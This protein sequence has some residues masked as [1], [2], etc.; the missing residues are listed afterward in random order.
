M[1]RDRS[2]FKVFESKKGGNVT[3]GDGSKSQIKGKRIISLPGLLDIANMLYVECL[4]VNLLSISQIFDQ[5]FM[6]L[7]S[8]GKCLVLDKSGKKLISGVRT[9]DNC[10]SLN[11]VVERKNRVFQEMARAMLHNKGVARNLWGETVN[12]A[13]HTVNRVYFR[14]DTKKTPYELWKGRKPNV[15]YFRIFGSTYFILKDRENVGKFDSRS[16]EG[17]FLGYSS[18]SK[19]YRV[20][21][22][23]T[24]KVMETVDVVIDE[25]SESFSENVSEEIPKEILPPEPKDIQEPVDQ[26]PASPST[27]G[28]PSVAEG[29]ADRSFLPDTESHKEKGPSSRIQLNHH[30]ETIVGNMNELTLRKCIVDKC[31][32]NFVSYSCYLSQFPD[33]VL[34]LKKALYGLKQASRA[35]YDRLTQYLVSHGFTRGKADQTFFIKREDDELIVAQVYVD[36]VIFGS[37]K[38]ELAHGFSKR[39]QVEFEM[40]M[41]GELNHFLGLQI[42]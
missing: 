7:F 26:E 36:D 20:Y 29:S 8:K 41:I 40:S 32:A 17:I 10:Y 9:L 4:R 33:H 1:T 22:K 13:C 30:L 2:L 23:R 21:N 39:M 24:K 34:Y 14:L 27:L 11:G 3:F 19:A 16:D 6:V 31:V 5:D 37:T 12:T 38:D 18:T 28:T 15:K 35:W 25:A 42:H